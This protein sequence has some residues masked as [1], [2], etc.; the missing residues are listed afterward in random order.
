MTLLHVHKTSVSRTLP[1]RVKAL[2]SFSD[3]CKREEQHAHRALKNSGYSNCFIHQ[4][5]TKCFPPLAPPPPAMCLS[6][7]QNQWLQSFFPTYGDYQNPS[8]ECC[9]NC[10]LHQVLVKP[11]DSVPE[12]SRN[13]VVYRI[14]S[15]DCPKTYIEEFKRSLL[16][17]LKE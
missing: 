14:P 8:V 13:G 2:S 5:A 12:M 6:P 10:T 11:K 17:S 1:A 15:W 16:R 4:T 3:G 7:D 9:S